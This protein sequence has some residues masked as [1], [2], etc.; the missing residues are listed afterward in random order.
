[1]AEAWWG[2]LD[3]LL[4]DLPPGT[5]DIAISTAHLLPRSELIIV[6][7]P[8]AAA[9]DVAI[10]AGMLAPQLNQRI[11]GVIENMSSFACPHCGEPID[12]FGHGGGAMVSEALSATMGTDV[13]LLGKIPFDPRLRE[14]GDA[15]APFVI[16]HA[17]AP[18]A[19]ALA[20]IAKTLGSKPRGLAGMSLNISPSRN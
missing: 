20:D 6:T 11:A 19:I 7:T 14:D 18:A 9:A 13:P 12:M 8:Q 3:V 2:D 17:D 16:D 1:L 15:G 5:G 4:L 10:R